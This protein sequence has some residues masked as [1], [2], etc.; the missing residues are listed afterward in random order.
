MQIDFGKTASDYGRHRAGFPG[1]FFERIF[2]AELVSPQNRVLDLGTG[3]GSL[4]RGLAL[5]GCDVTGLDPSV[6]M[7]DQSRQLDREA[8]VDIRYVNE[9]AEQTGLPDRAFDVVTAGQCWHWFDRPRAAAEVQRLLVPGGLLLIAHFDWLPLPGSAV[10][11]TEALIL[12]HNPKWAPMA[13]GNGLH[14]WWFADLEQAGFDAIES[15]TFDLGVPYTHEAWLGRIRASAGVG[16]SLPPDAVARFDADHKALL[17]RDFPQE[18]LSIPH[19]VFV[20]YGRTA[21]HA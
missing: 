6:S 19:R 10:A 16:A 3:T 21:N 17:K 14:P 11:A 2:R 15:F 4:A 7:I 8:N 20:I 18:V 1:E 9:K 5:R 13:G 12:E